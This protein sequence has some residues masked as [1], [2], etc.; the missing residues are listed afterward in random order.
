MVGT[1]SL[2]RWGLA[3]VAILALL[4]LIVAAFPFGMLKG[5][6]ADRLSDRFGRPVT[7]DSMAR[8]DGFGFTPT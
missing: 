5:L 2:G 4:L 1:R 7:I 3:A 8:T 6:V